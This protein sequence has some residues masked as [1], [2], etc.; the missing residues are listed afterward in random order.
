MTH[1]CGYVPGYAKSIYKKSAQPVK[2]NEKLYY[3]ASGIR[4]FCDLEVITYLFQRLLH[5]LKQSTKFFFEIIFNSFVVFTLILIHD[6]KSLSFI[7][8]D[9]NFRKSQKSWG[10]K[11]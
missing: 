11:F 1:N 7:K 2:V 6:L 5:F 10:V 9:L 4:A 8:D 3:L